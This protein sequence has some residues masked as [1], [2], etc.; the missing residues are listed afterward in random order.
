MSRHAIGLTCAAVTLLAFSA[1]RA[2]TP[3]PGQTL[4]DTV[5]LFPD[6]TRLSS[7]TL[8]L[9]GSSVRGVLAN[10]AR[11]FGVVRAV[12]GDTLVMREQSSPGI[13]RLVP[14]GSLQRLE[15]RRQGRS[16]SRN[17]QIGSV[18]GAVAGGLVYLNFC[19]KHPNQCRTC[20]HSYYGDEEED[21]QLDLGSTM[22]LAGAFVGGAIAY[23]L[24]PPSWRR[25]GVQLNGA[26]APDGDGGTRAALGARV[27]LTLLAGRR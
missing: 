6:T 13:P 15:V 4:P 23:A 25:V 26:V 16:L 27:P 7:D 9:A 21:D 2:Q 22:V 14:S 20:Q 3:D 8:R 17:V 10:G 18:I 12:R 19:D 11:F 24:T 5:R 1:A